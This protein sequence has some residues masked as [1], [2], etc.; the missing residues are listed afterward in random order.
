[1][2][3]RSSSSK[4]STGSSTG[5]LLA[6]GTSN[7]RAEVHQTA[8]TEDDDMTRSIPQLIFSTRSPS[9]KSG[10]D[11]VREVVA[12]SPGVAEEVRAEFARRA[13]IA[14]S[15]LQHELRQA[16]YMFCPVAANAWLLC[17]A[18][19]LGLY[20]KGSNLLL[21]HGVVLAEEHLEA[22]EG[23]PL[24]LDLPEVQ[25]RRGLAFREEYP[26]AGRH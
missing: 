10:P 13:D 1:M 22:L 8:P 9:P 2:S 17:R 15:I 4:S 16:V 7:L 5:P 12:E 21:V 18:M 6:R 26:G 3:S 20:R 19:S 25:E 24:L 14:G 23:N 11:F